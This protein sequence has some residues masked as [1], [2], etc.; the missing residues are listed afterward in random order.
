MGEG[1]LRDGCQRV[2]RR[3]SRKRGIEKVGRQSEGG[4]NLGEF[5]FLG[6][7]RHGGR[8]KHRESGAGG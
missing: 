7:E 4:K 5:S 3:I 6:G 2:V 1:E 8:K